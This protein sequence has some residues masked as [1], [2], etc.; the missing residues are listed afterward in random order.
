MKI[1]IRILQEI[2]VIVSTIV[3]NQSG[4]LIPDRTE[5]IYKLLKM[6]SELEDMNNASV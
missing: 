1:I 3:V 5:V 4:E 2:I 6:H